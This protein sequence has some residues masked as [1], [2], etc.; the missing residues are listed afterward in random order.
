M[1]QFKSTVCIL[2]G[3]NQYQYINIRLDK[4]VK[5]QYVILVE[6]KI[7]FNSVCHSTLSQN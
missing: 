1:Q 3:I 6:K 2:H 5:I 4:E 7:Y